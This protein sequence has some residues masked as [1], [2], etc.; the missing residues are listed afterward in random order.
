MKLVS[1]NKSWFPL[2]TLDIL[3][4]IKL[5]SSITWYVGGS[6]NHLIT[7]AIMVMVVAVVIMI[8]VVVLVIVDLLQWI[9]LTYHVV[10][11]L[12]LHS[13]MWPMVISW[14]KAL[15]VHQSRALQ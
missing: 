11:F 14:K 9:S 3:H 5:L 4:T 15:V 6:F 12:Q 10:F 13:D 2:M 8:V 7:I 1:G